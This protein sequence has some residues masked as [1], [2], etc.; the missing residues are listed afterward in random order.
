MSR[1]IEKVYCRGGCN[2]INAVFIS[3]DVVFVAIADVVD[4]YDFAVII[5]D[6]LDATIADAVVVDD[7]IALC[8][9]CC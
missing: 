4:Y 3:D 9:S 6:V 1:C 8:Y 5:D 2:V 7:A